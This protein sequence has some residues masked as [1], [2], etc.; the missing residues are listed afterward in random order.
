MAY[1]NFARALPLVLAHEGGY[2]NNPKDPGKATNL[3]ITIGTLSD[4]LGRPATNADVRALTRVSVTPIYHDRYW[5]AVRGD[6]LPP[7]I[8]YAV[9][10]YAVNSGPAR[11]IMGVQRYLGIADDGVLGPIT[12]REIREADPG[13]VIRG[14]CAERMAFLRKLST[15]KTFG[16]GWTDRVDG[17]RTHALAMAADVLP[18]PGPTRQPDDPGP[19]PE[20]PEPTQPAAPAA[21]FSLSWL[22]S[23]FR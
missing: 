23:W 5:D 10:D 16:N 12:I 6:D 7:G 9:F 2:V 22:W 20:P 13:D 4:W 11:A 8:D 17:V 19:E 14:L 1:G 3:G 18:G 21:G 15:W